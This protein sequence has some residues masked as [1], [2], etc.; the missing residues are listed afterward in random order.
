MADKM[1]CKNGYLFF[2]FT[3]FGPHSASCLHEVKAGEHWVLE[4][5]GAQ[6]PEIVEELIYSIYQELYGDRITIS[7]S[8]FFVWF[9]EEMTMRKNARFMTC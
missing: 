7:Y 4:H 9:A 3:T 6:E 2:P 8:D 5:G 1:G